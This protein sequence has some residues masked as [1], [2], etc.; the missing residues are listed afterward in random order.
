MVEVDKYMS[1]FPSMEEY[2]IAAN[3][4]TAFI[5]EIIAKI[6][7]VVKSPEVYQ[8]KK[9]EYRVK[10]ITGNNN[11]FEFLFI[12]SQMVLQDRQKLIDT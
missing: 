10:K 3:K 1:I 11:Y 9:N 12:A 8:Q 4:H 2:F 7:I 6:P 5:T